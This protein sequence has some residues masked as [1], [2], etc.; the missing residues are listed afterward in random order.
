MTTQTGCPR[1]GVHCLLL[2]ALLLLSACAP[3]AKVAHW[4]SVHDEFSGEPLPAGLHV[5]L[6]GSRVL[7]GD[8]PTFRTTVGPGGQL[9]DPVPDDIWR[10]YVYSS[11][12]VQSDVTEVARFA[13]PTYE[14]DGSAGTEQAIPLFGSRDPERRFR[15]TWTRV[16]EQPR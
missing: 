13:I 3:Q 11:G 6:R 4:I 12:E 1:C 9:V 2:V 10:V 16:P 8:G 14:R 5:T 7:G 15:V